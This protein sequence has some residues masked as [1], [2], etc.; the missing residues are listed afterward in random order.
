MNKAETEL[1]SSFQNDHN[2]AEQKPW[3]Q[4]EHAN[5]I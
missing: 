2:L 5:H 3:Q 4:R 1:S